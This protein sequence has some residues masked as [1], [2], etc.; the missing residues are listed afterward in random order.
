MLLRLFI[1]FSLI[2]L[3]GAL[4]FLVGYEVEFSLFYL[5]PIA[6]I[7]WFVG[8]SFGFIASI[9]SAGIWLLADVASGHTYPNSFTPIW[10]TLVRLS[11]YVVVSLLLSSLRRALDRESKL[12]RTDSLTGAVNARWFHELAQMEIDRLGRHGRPLTLMYIDLDN[13]KTV[14]DRFGHIAGDRALQSIVRSIKDQIRTSDVIAR[15]GGDEFA[16]LLPETNQKVAHVVVS[17]LQAKLHKEMERNHWPVTFSIGVLTCQTVVPSIDQL[18]HMTDELM[19]SVK[20][21]SKNDAKYAT[22]EG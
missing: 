14:N 18:V 12:A 6:F 1:G 20:N 10:N 16:V 2:G 13:F 19:F 17:K 7:S 4:E 15:L 11:F 8:R 9:V 5:I 22:Y 21:A 3:V